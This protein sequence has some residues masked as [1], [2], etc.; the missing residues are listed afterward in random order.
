MRNKGIFTCTVINNRRYW[1]SMVL[2]NDVGN[3]FG[4]VEVWETNAIQGTVDYSIYNLCV[5]KLSSYVMRMMATYGR[6]LVDDTCKETMRR[7]NENG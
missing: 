1:P 4:K 5:M 2:G 7:W 3:H 6:L